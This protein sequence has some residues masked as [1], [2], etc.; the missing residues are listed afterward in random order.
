MAACWPTRRA[1]LSA[2]TMRMLATSLITRGIID[3]GIGVGAAAAIALGVYRLT[4]GLMTLQALL[5]V[6]MSGTEIFRPLRDFR[7]VLA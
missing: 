3:V 2:A 4:H 6:L 5:I 1:Q 7:T